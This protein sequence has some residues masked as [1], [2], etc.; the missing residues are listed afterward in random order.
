MGGHS[1]QVPCNICSKPV[2]LSVDLCADE[3][4]K[5]I[6]EDCY[7][8]RVASSRTNPPTSMMAD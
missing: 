5:A 6:H 8:K 2:D 1:P 4:G 3:E 7:V